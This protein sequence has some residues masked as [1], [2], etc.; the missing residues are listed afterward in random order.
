MGVD[1]RLQP[2]RN[3]IDRLVPR[4]LGKFAGAADAFQRPQHAV[5]IVGYVDDRR[6]LDADMPLR[7]RI[8][9]IRRQLDRA[10]VLDRHHRPAE[11]LA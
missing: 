9:A 10:A 4:N 7:V 6:A 8:V 2:R 5:G 1:D 3:I 11:G